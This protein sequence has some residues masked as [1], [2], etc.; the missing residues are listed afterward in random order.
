MEIKL[1]KDPILYTEPKVFLYYGA[2]KI[3]KTTI[4]S[5]LPNAAILDTEEGSGY[6]SCIR[7]N[8]GSL[9]ELG[10]FRDAHI[11]AG[12]PHKFII[13]DTITQCEEWTSRLATEIYMGTTKG[14]SFNRNSKGQLL[15]EIEWN[16]VYDELGMNAILYIRRAWRE[17]FTNYLYPACNINTR[18]ILIGHIKDKF[19]EGASNMVST[20][21]LDLTGRLKNIT[22]QTISD[23]NAYCYRDSKNELQFSFKPELGDISAGSRVGPVGQVIPANKLWETLYPETLKAIT[24]K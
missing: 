3:G 22:L 17:L 7:Y 23:S 20:K 10:A 21:E 1:E 13:V 18:L 5:V 8:I 15:P 16:N 2:E 19:M 9:E 4:A 12:Y 14:K 11:K 24:N 6:V